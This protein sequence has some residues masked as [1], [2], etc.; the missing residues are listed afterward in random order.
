MNTKAQRLEK[1]A[2]QGAH[3]DAS[4]CSTVWRE[5]GLLR[6]V[7]AKK[8]QIENLLLAVG[9]LM[10]LLLVGGCVTSAE[11]KTSDSYMSKSNLRTGSTYLD[12]K[13]VAASQERM[14]NAIAVPAVKDR[15][16][17][18]G[19]TIAQPG[20]T[21]TK[22]MPFCSNPTVL[23]KFEESLSEE[24]KKIT[25]PLFE[26]RNI[27]VGPATMD[28]W[29]GE[30]GLIMIV[31]LTSENSSC[32]PDPIVKDEFRVE[33]KITGQL[34]FLDA[35]KDMQV[36]ASYPLG[37]VQM[38][39]IPGIA[40]ESDYLELAREALV[41]DDRADDKK[42]LSLR[43]QITDQLKGKTIVPRGVRAPVAVGKVTFDGACCSASLPEGTVDIGGPILD[44]W[45]EQFGFTFANYL[46]IGNGLAVNPYGS[47][48]NTANTVVSVAASLTMRTVDNKQVNAKLG[49]PRL[50]FFLNFDRL[51][52]AQNAESDRYTKILDYGF[53]GSV[54]VVNSDLGG[55][56]VLSLGFDLPPGKSTK[57]PKQLIEKYSAIS[58]TRFLRKVFGDGQVDNQYWW[59]EAIDGFLLQLS[60][61]IAFDEEDLGHRFQ[62]L[63]E[64][65]KDSKNIQ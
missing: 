10:F 3:C 12:S 54:R 18:G 65:L 34:L 28:N 55:R 45:T 14:A 38:D 35:K 24:L 11:M 20:N 5:T 8:H 57:L 62:K 7:F 26:L 63:R 39:V 64:Q 16:F 13:A 6:W 37:V 43:D 41:S 40:T 53:R 21:A 56:E 61:E 22:N 27:G 42:A 47:T 19:V 29:K 4:Q 58:E 52:A 51:H 33:L 50:V 59:Q 9:C 48:T 32:T 31:S 1:P 17:W 25:P 30:D 15:V 2:G 23:K 44:R 60:R 36:T 49:A 46:G